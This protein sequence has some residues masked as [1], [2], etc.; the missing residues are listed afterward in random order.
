RL[1]AGCPARDRVELRRHDNREDRRRIVGDRGLRIPVAPI[2]VDEIRL[3]RHP[4][5]LALEL[6]RR[7]TLLNR[8]G[9]AD[10]G[11]RRE[12]PAVDYRQLELRVR[13]DTGRQADEYAVLPDDT[14]M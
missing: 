10:D 7:G 12:A 1:A 3:Q 11:L 8:H 5:Y 6:H 9:F 2:A 13:R 4:R 14:Q